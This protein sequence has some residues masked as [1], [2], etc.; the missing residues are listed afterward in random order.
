MCEIQFDVD[1]ANGVAI[2]VANDVLPIWWMKLYLLILANQKHYYMPQ[3][4][5][6]TLFGLGPLLWVQY[7]NAH[8]V[9]TFNT[10]QF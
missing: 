9:H 10:I 5:D 4:N 6:I 3:L 7:P 8:I 2:D 1:V